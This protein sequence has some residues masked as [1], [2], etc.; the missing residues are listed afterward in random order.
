MLSVTDTALDLLILQL[1]LHGLRGCVATVL[2]G[3]LAPVDTGSEDDVLGHRGGIG[4]RA[5]RVLGAEAELGPRFSVRDSGVHG[6]GVGDVS[7]AASGLDLLAFIV[8][9]VG[10]DRLGSV[11]VGDGLG[12]RELSCGGGGLLDVV[13]VGPVVP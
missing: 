7:D 8:V 13:V 12:G 3:I 10:D 2:L 11:L 5:G 4:G 6:L 1:V 9:L